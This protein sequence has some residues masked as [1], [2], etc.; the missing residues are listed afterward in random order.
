MSPFL[1]LNGHDAMSD[2][3]PLSGVERKHL[4]GMSISHFGPT[5]D[6]LRPLE[7][8]ICACIGTGKAEARFNAQNLR[9]RRHDQ[10]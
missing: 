4:L 7:K 3:S 5:A 8:I 1:A 10:V 2:L 6:M 9:K